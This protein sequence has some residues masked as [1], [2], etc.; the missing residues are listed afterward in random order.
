MATAESVSA[1]MTQSLVDNVYERMFGDQG[2]HFDL[3]EGTASTPGGAKVIYLSTDIIVGI[4]TA[5]EYEAGEAWTVILKSCGK[6]W[7]KRVLSALEK[8]LRTVA[9]RRFDALTVTEY[10]VLIEKY[11]SYHGWGRVSF[12]LDGIEQHGILQI[13][14]KDSI[15]R[16]ALPQVTGPVDYM[17]AGMLVGIFEQLAQTELDVLQMEVKTNDGV[18]L[19]HFLLSSPERVVWGQAQADAGSDYAT[20]LKEM[21]QS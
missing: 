17:V 6:R 14:L 9:N 18:A 13:D 10:V 16:Y 19:T 15:F 21:Q 3:F 8:E 11:F 2:Q 1:S 7:G 4:Y 12:R 5:I 20:V